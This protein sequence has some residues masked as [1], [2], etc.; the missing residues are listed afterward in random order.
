MSTQSAGPTLF[1]LHCYIP[2]VFGLL[3][4]FL[5]PDT[6]DPFL[7][8][9]RYHFRL[10]AFLFRRAVG[11]FAAKRLYVIAQGFYE[12]LGY[13]SRG[14]RPEWR[15]RRVFRLFACYCATANIGCHFQGTLY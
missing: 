9:R 8:V 3:R 7:M 5:M 1:H 12:A 4:L 10:W 2:G 11:T 13:A 14:I 15:P 6:A